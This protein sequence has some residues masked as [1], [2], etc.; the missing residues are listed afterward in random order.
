[1]ATKQELHIGQ[2]MKSVCDASGLSVAELARRI[3]TVRS[4]VYFIFERP[5]IDMEQLLDLCDA[6]NH[7]FLDDIQIRRGMKSNLCAREIRIE[8]NLDDLS[9]E[10]AVRVCRF[11][12]ELK[13]E[14]CL[15]L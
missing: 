12:E 2:M 5:S 1:M 10:K 14:N 3:H 15:K 9:D 6:L 11:L 8:L 13:G 7:N 4:N